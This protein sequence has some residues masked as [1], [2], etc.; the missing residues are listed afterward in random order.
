MEPEPGCVLET[1]HDVIDFFARLELSPTQQARLAVCYDCCHQALQF[2][3]PAESLKLLADNGIRIGH[4]QVSSALRLRNPD[5]SFLKRFQE[6]CY[7]HQT[8]GRKSDGELLRYDDLDPAISA[9]PSDVDGVEEWRVH[10]HVPVFM[11]AVQECG[12]SRFFLEEIL[13][14]FPRS[15]L[16]KWKPIPG[17]FF[18]LSCKAELSRIA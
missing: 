4:V 6:S 15:C 17:P 10:F 5:I 16:W 1:T 14:L 12:S 13:P 7:L 9:A 8:V 3:S 18:R 11:E 2:E